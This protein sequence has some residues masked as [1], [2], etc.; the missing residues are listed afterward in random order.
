MK[1]Q[2]ESRTSTRSAKAWSSL[3]L[4]TSLSASAFSAFDSAADPA[5]NDGLQAGDNGGIGWQP[6]SFTGAGYSMG[7]SNTNGSLAGPGINTAGRSWSLGDGV[8]TGSS[9]RYLNTPLGIGDSMYFD[10][11]TSSFASV[12][13][14]SG[15]SNVMTIGQTGNSLFLFDSNGFTSSGLG[16]ADRGVHVKVTRTSG[17]Q[18]T[19]ELTRLDTSAM[20]TSVRNG[21]VALNGIRSQWDPSV[22]RFYINSMGADPVPEPASLAAIGLGVAGMLARKRKRSS[23]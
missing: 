13:L 1:Q 7:D 18:M 4:A 12:Y 17:T 19:Y 22:S 9:V 8:N 21:S 23:D 3:V 15:G 20:F 14:V 16:G 5:Y 10:I 2:R 11:D 6:W